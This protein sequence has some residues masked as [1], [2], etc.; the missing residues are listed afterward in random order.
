MQIP[1]PHPRFLKRCLSLDSAK[2]RA[3]DKDLC[4]RSLNGDP[5][6]ALVRGLR[7]GNREERKANKRYINEKV[8]SVGKWDSTPKGSE[9]L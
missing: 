4:A 9:R 8:I 7:K 1:G 6:S 5:N 2:S 3:L